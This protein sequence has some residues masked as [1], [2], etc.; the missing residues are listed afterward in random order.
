[1][2]CKRMGKDKGKKHT[3]SATSAAVKDVE[4]RSVKDHL[5]K[6][7][8]SPI[9]HVRLMASKA[10]LVLSLLMQLILMQPLDHTE[11]IDFIETFAGCCSV[12]KAFAA[13]GKLACPFEIQLDRVA[14]DIMSDL[15]L[16]HLLHMLAR[17]VDGGM[18][19]T[20]PVCSTWTWMNSGTSG[21]TSRRP[22]GRLDVQSVS[23][24]NEM[25]A[26]VVLCLYLASAKGMWWCLEQPRGSL[27]ARHP[28]FLELAA[29]LPVFRHSFNMRDH[30]GGSL[31]PTWIYSNRDFVS[32]LDEVAAG[33]SGEAPKQLARRY[34][35][36]NGRMRVQ[37]TEHLKGSQAYP[38]QFG[39]AVARIYQRHEEQLKRDAAIAKADALTLLDANHENLVE[40]S[41]NDSDL[42][43]DAGLSSVL[44]YLQVVG[45]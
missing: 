17:C 27:L 45:A 9:L 10:P 22:L 15:G 41:C 7:L 12:T 36:G 29:N 35:D 37:G 18:F 44:S 8:C 43:T 33:A 31:K 38:V 3:K 32:E 11:V 20:A 19:W 39:L 40:M 30:G 26:R 23:V 21:R 2:G 4:G 1:M 5:A 42:W 28:R 14:G 16:V 6:A 13:L 34:E 24:A 25:V